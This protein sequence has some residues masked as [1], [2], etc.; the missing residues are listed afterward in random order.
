MKPSPIV[1][2]TLWTDRPVFDAPFVGLLGTQVHWAFNR[3][4]LWGLKG[5]GQVL[6]L[7]ISGAHEAIKKAPADIFES[8]WEDLRNCFPS[9]K[10]AKIERWTVIKEP[11]ATLSPVVGSD[12]LRPGHRTSVNRF[13]IAGDWT[14]TGLPATIESA[15]K[16]GHAVAEILLG[17]T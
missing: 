5:P 7:T 3:T 11:Y 10:K 15:A 16:S 2:V 8:A 13:F 9:A 1:G 4:R 6:A 12:A 14:Q 17:E